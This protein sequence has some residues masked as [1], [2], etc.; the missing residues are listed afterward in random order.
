MHGGFDM[1]IIDLIIYGCAV[2]LWLIVFTTVLLLRKWQINKRQRISRKEAKTMVGKGWSHLLDRIYDHVPADVRF[3][4]IKEKWAALRVYYDGGDDA[5]DRIVSDAEKES[6]TTCESCG[7]V[8]EIKLSLGWW[9][10]FCDSCRE[11]DIK[12]FLEMRKK[13]E[14]RMKELSID[15]K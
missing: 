3:A 15:E 4:Q 13:H 6:S 7:K 14:A 12:N 1:D 9:K 10:C 5:F 2:V 8:G 11:Q